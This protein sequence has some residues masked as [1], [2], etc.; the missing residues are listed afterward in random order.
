MADLIQIRRDIK[1]VW[2][3]ANP[4]LFDGEFG[5]DKTSK[6]F[7]IGDGIN[8]W[9]DLLYM[10]DVTLPTKLSDLINDLNLEGTY[11][12]KKAATE[13][14]VSSTEKETWNG[15]QDLLE[16]GVNLKTINNKSLLGSENINIEGNI[17]GG[18]ANS[19]YLPSQ[20]INGGNANG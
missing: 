5:L 8:A 20:V 2:E 4:I 11:Q 15:K 1:T 19:V 6:K 17:D 3:S 14:Y 16:S 7:K 13:L 18:S 10:N 12:A 9:N